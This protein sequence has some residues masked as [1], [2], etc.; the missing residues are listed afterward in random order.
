MMS[1]AKKRKKSDS[2]TG[3][4]QTLA[5]LIEQEGDYDVDNAIWDLHRYKR[6]R[7][8]DALKKAQRFLKMAIR[9]YDYSE[10]LRG[11]TLERYLEEPS[12]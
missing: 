4:Y 11:N 6:D 9:E 5:D 1:K 3:K 12:K 8:L 7:S 2:N 10:H